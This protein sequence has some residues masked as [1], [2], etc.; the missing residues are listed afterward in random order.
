MGHDRPV[1]KI[2]PEKRQG[3]SVIGDH[4]ADQ[5]PQ[6]VGAH[7]KRDEACDGDAQMQGNPQIA[8]R[9]R[10]ESVSG[11]IWPQTPYVIGVPKRRS[12]ISRL[13]GQPRCPQKP[14]FM[15]SFDGLQARACWA[16][17]HP[18]TWPSDEEAALVNP[19]CPALTAAGATQHIQRYSWRHPVFAT[20]SAASCTDALR[21]RRSNHKSAGLSG[22]KSPVQDNL[23]C[24]EE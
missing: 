21:A 23:Q 13:N 3:C 10:P 7:T 20:R 5:R 24:R 9:I 15:P 22:P 8:A 16:L 2:V 18:C 4:E 6:R 12:D 11:Q 19:V 14:C 1:R 17:Y